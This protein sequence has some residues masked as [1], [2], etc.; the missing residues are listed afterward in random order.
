MAE[1]MASEMM[2]TEP[3]SMPAIIFMTI[4]LILEQTET[5]AA[6]VF[7]VMGYPYSR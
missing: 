2:L 6:L 3:L 5:K 4:R 1:W 7:L